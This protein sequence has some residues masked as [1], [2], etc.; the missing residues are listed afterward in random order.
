MCWCVGDEEAELGS[1][2]GSL[3]VVLYQHPTGSLFYSL[4]VSLSASYARNIISAL[5]VLSEGVVNL[6]QK[7]KIEVTRVA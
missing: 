7:I 2:R 6:I 5:P 4:P 3:H 1:G